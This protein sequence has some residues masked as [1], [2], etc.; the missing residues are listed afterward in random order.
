MSIL[1]FAENA[2]D[3]GGRK[4]SETK[5]GTEVAACERFCETLQENQ[6]RTYRELQE[7]IEY[8]NAKKNRLLETMERKH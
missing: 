3:E 1:S 6:D 5:R 4:K 7:A 2:C 8:M